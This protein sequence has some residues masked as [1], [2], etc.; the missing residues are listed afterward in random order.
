MRGPMALY[1]Q[2]N[3]YK[4]SNHLYKLTD[5]PKHKVPPVYASLNRFESSTAALQ[6]LSFYAATQK[7][8]LRTKPVLASS[9]S[10]QSDAFLLASMDKH[11]SQDGTYRQ[12][13]RKRPSFRQSIYHSDPSNSVPFDATH[14]NARG[15]KPESH[16]SISIFNPNDLAASFHSHHAPP[17]SPSD[18]AIERLLDELRQTN[19]SPV[20]SHRSSLEREGYVP[21]RLP[22]LHPSM[23]PRHKPVPSSS[24]DTKSSSLHKYY[25]KYLP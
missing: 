20:S 23:R 10:N 8:P 3:A 5:R 13:R 12:R 17:P 22:A 11:M 4:K 24:K 21:F 16:R 6:S 19:V 14:L 25:W 2:S 18:D 15:L 9:G 1:E 7:H